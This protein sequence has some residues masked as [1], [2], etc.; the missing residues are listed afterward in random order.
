M[1]PAIEDH[2]PD[3][4]AQAEKPFRRARGTGVRTANL[5]FFVITP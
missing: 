2:T 1:E 5:S 3:R 4:I